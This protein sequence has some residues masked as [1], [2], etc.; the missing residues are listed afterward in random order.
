MGSTYKILLLHTKVGWLSPGKASVQ[1]S[2]KLKLSI[3]HGTSYLLGRTTGRQTIAIIYLV[4]IVYSYR[5][6]YLTDISQI[7]KVR[8]SLKGKVAIF[9]SMIKFKLLRENRTL[10]NFYLPL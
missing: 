3:F 6:G 2:C 9:V 7:N 8:L 5:L 4:I 1:P 10:E